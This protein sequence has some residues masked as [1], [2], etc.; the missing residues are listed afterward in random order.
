MMQTNNQRLIIA[1]Q[2]AHRKRDAELPKYNM[3]FLKV[4]RNLNNTYKD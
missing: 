1:Q 3:M 4:L 2:N